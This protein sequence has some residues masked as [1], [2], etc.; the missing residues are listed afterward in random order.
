MSV[1][2]LR[3]VYFLFSCAGPTPAV[4]PV[5]RILPAS[6]LCTSLLVLMP[7]LRMKEARVC[8]I[9]RLHR[10]LFFTCINEATHI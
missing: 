8:V 4:L 5:G 2:T 6:F 7:R 9:H 1:H 3:I 10:A